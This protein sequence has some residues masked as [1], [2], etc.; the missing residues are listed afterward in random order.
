MDHLTLK[1][2]FS[3]GILIDLS[4]VIIAL[5]ALV[6]SLNPEFGKYSVGRELF[7]VTGICLGMTALVL[8]WFTFSYN[9]CQTADKYICDI[10]AEQRNKSTFEYLEVQVDK[11]MN[12]LTDFL[13]HYHL[14]Y[15]RV[16]LAPDLH[17]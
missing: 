9:K 3:N 2:F 16:N 12:Y 15:K 1:E 11:V 10:I 13:N 6:F 7:E 8:M 17:I 14:T 4:G 5:I